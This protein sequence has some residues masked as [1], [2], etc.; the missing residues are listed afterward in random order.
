MRSNQYQ[1]PSPN[2]ASER[3]TTVLASP[4]TV[5]DSTRCCTPRAF[6]R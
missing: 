1:P 2:C 3:S 4:E 5:C 6:E